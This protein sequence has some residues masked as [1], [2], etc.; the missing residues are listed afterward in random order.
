MRSQ[1]IHSNLIDEG[2]NP[3]SFKL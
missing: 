1:L 3:I 2:I